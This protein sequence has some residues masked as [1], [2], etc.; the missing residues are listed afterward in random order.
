MVTS[1][2]LFNLLKS[3]DTEE[4]KSFVLS[5]I[6][7]YTE[8]YSQNKSFHCGRLIPRK[9]ERFNMCAMF[10]WDSPSIDEAIGSMKANNSKP[11]DITE[12]ENKLNTFRDKNETMS[13]W[14]ESL[15][16]SLNSDEVVDLSNGIL[17]IST[18]DL[19]KGKS[20]E[21]F[22]EFDKRVTSQYSLHLKP[23]DW[24]YQGTFKIRRGERNIFGEL[25]YIKAPSPEA[26]LERDKG[27][28]EPQEIT[29][30]IKKC[31]TFPEPG[32]KF[33]FWL[34]PFVIS[35]YAKKGIKFI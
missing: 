3:T 7:R 14:I 1:F 19:A 34:E 30:I 23:I 16:P 26:A 31:S 18:Y 17:R 8:Y 6:G 5:T 27:L 2:H 35:E 32:S 9:T 11:N 4:Y 10:Q 13:I 29:D 15:V 20:A 12:I 33:G 24:L 22:V 21:E 28:G 25:D